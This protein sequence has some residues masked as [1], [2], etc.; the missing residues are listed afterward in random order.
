MPHA[1]PVCLC[2]DAS[3]NVVEHAKM[4]PVPL[5]SAPHI[6]ESA[7]DTTSAQVFLELVCVLCRCNRRRW[8]QFMRV[9]WGL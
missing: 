4:L 1:Y 6:S 9:K 8:L 2:P 7:S 3:H 5:R